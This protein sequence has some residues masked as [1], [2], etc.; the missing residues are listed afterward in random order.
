[1]CFRC[2]ARGVKP[3][4]G[5]DEPTF[6]R[7]VDGGHR[8][9]MASKWPQPLKDLFADCWQQEPAA[10]PEFASVAQR[11]EQILAQLQ[12]DAK[13]SKAKGKIA[14]RVAIASV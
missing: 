13:G 14:K 1:M 12:A 8:P 2:T 3:F 5:F 6:K 4:A 10:R 7:A 9:A 11:L